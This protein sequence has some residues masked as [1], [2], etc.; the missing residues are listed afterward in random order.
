MRGGL[1][2][3]QRHDSPLRGSDTFSPNLTV[4]WHSRRVVWK[5]LLTIASYVSGTCNRESRV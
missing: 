2:H 5:D 4:D 3:G 1:K